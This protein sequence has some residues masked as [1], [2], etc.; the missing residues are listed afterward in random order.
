[1][2]A[3]RVTEILAP[4]DGFELPL[5]PAEKSAPDVFRWLDG[6]RVAS[7]KCT[8]YQGLAMFGDCSVQFA[9]RTALRS[10]DGHA[11]SHRGVKRRLEILRTSVAPDLP[12]H[13]LARKTSPWA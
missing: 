9:P 13:V 4:R 11:R 5:T 2:L 6:Y 3:R 7:Q 8:T 12:C 10:P 1:M